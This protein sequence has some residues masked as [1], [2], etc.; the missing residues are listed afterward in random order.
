MS[1]N[2]TRFWR[3]HEHLCTEEDPECPA[4]AIEILG[5]ERDEARG[6]L[7]ELALGVSWSSAAT[8]SSRTRIDLEDALWDRIRSAVKEWNPTY[9]RLA[10]L[11]R[12][13]S[14]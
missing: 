8:W 4:C 7:I 1:E 13:K 5:K 6:L 3:L 2:P 11:E 9:L 12:G 10:E 14:Q